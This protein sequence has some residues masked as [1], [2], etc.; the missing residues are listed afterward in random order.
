MNTELER[1]YSSLEPEEL[2]RIVNAPEEYTSE[3][4]EA[5]SSELRRRN[6]KSQDILSSSKISTIALAKIALET[7]RR[8]DIAIVSEELKRR[9]LWENLSRSLQTDSGYSTNSMLD[10]ILPE[11]IRFTEKFDELLALKRFN[12][13]DTDAINVLLMI[14][15]HVA[16]D[17]LTGKQEEETFLRLRDI[18]INADLLLQVVEP[19]YRRVKSSLLKQKPTG[20]SYFYALF[21][22]LLSAIVGGVGYGLFMISTNLKHNFVLI[23]LGVLS[24]LLMHLMTG[25]KKGAGITFIGIFSTVLSIL[26]GNVIYAVHRSAPLPL[27]RF[28]F[29][30]GIVGLTGVVGL[31]RMIKTKSQ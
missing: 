6:I 3:A 31:S 15:Q 1:R 25:G 20:T 22:G 5:A 17:I 28:D 29:I 11:G 26:L 4:I 19:F 27:T 9:N 12:L 8:E 24:G 21:A 16:K 10:E 2:I 7:D 30:W 14:F 13:A 18:G 23:F